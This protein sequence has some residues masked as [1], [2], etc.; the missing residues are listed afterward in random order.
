MGTKAMGCCRSHSIKEEVYQGLLPSGDVLNYQMLAN[1]FASKPRRGDSVDPDMHEEI[2]QPFFET[3][4]AR[5]PLDPERRAE[6]FLTIQYKTRYDGYPCDKINDPHTRLCVLIDCSGSMGK[7]FLPGDPSMSKLEIACYMVAALMETVPIRK[8]NIIMFNE[9]ARVVWPQEEQ[10]GDNKLQ[11][12]YQFG[13]F[14]PGTTKASAATAL[15]TQVLRSACGASNLSNAI[16]LAGLCFETDAGGDEN[17]MDR[18][19]IISDMEVNMGD[20]TVLEIGDDLKQDD[21]FQGELHQTN[22]DGIPWVERVRRGALGGMHGENDSKIFFTTVIGLG[23]HV[24]AET[25]RPLSTVRG[26]SSMIVSSPKDVLWAYKFAHKES[27]DPTQSAPGVAAEGADQSSERFDS[28]NPNPTNKNV[29]VERQHYGK[30]IEDYQRNGGV[31]DHL[32]SDDAAGARGDL[33]DD[34]SFA[35]RVMQ[36][37]IYP[38]AFNLR[39]ELHTGPF[40]IEEVVGLDRSFKQQ[41][42]DDG[43]ILQVDTVFPGQCYSGDQNSR[44]GELKNH[45]KGN[46]FLVKL[47]RK[48]ELNPMDKYHKQLAADDSIIQKEWL[49]VAWRYEKAPGFYEEGHQVVLASDALATKGYAND[50]KWK[51]ETAGQ[52]TKTSSQ[53][54]P[55]IHWDG[56]IESSGCTA[57]CRRCCGGSREEGIYGEKIEV[58]DGLP[59]WCSEYVP[60]TGGFLEENGSPWARKAVVLYR[61]LQV[62]NSVVSDKYITAGDAWRIE[63]FKDY[64]EEQCEFIYPTLTAEQRSS[65]PVFDAST[66]ENMVAE[67]MEH[68]NLLALARSIEKTTGYENLTCR[69]FCTC[70]VTTTYWCCP[71][72]DH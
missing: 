24:N 54:V 6:Y 13:D 55:V 2:I 21:N 33:K 4:I 28:W 47:R 12:A 36:C 39:F 72:C 69:G 71:W 66:H 1:S 30:L 68:L 5:D 41:T 15:K 65:E 34:R 8:L 67:Q 16:K 60:A 49:S 25:L 40:E 52:T 7:E 50:D 31:V 35:A 23:V 22:V 46:L 51:L 32:L 57:I 43:E 3:C 19:M 53:K 38:V 42:Q 44:S 10:D 61:V 37:T 58:A 45:V 20:E 56:P 26:A 63:K 59:A 64:I 27:L 70:C 14:E 11:T 62:A 29:T 18:L 17:M 48:F 9:L